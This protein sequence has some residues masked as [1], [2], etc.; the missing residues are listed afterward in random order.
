MNV[1]KHMYILGNWA[2][3]T[4]PFW[5]P[6]DKLDF[7]QSS[8]PVCNI[9]PFRN[10]A[11]CRC[12]MLALSIRFI[13]V[14]FDWPFVP[15]HWP[16]SHGV[17][18]GIRNLDLRWYVSCE[19]PAVLPPRSSLSPR[20]YRPQRWSPSGKCQ[21]SCIECKR[22]HSL[23]SSLAMT[24]AKAKFP[25]CSVPSQGHRKQTNSLVVVWCTCQKES[26][27]WQQSNQSFPGIYGP[28]GFG[29]RLSEV[30]FSTFWFRLW[31]ILTVMS[32]W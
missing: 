11:L 16:Q 13:E 29:N 28:Y 3:E 10:V 21:P 24:A 12:L 5:I 30:R 25:I 32:F 31:C 2:T 6:F 23:F 4:L 17:A 14:A 20:W 27:W 18:S 1:R 8:Q 15:H 26:I 9:V 22:K 7:L 19:P